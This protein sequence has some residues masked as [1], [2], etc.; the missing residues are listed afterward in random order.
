MFRIMRAEAAL[1]RSMPLETLDDGALVAHFECFG[2]TL[3]HE[4]ALR[5]LHEVVSAQSRAY[6]VLEALVTAWIP[7][8]D[9]GVMTRLMTGLGTLPNVRMTYGLM[10]LG[11]LAT[12]ER[13][14]RAYFMG[15][16]DAVAL[17]NYERALAGTAVLAGLREFLADFGHR[18]SYESD[19]MSVRFAE[20]PTALLRM[21]QL[22]V[23]AG[24]TGTAAAHAASRRE[25]RRA[26]MTEIRHTLRAACGPLGSR[27]RW[28]VFSMV[29][30]AVRRLLA[31]RDECRHVTTMLVT[32]L[33]R[34]A[35]EM[36]RRGARAGRLADSTDVF[37]LTWDEMSRLL[38]EGDTDWAAVAAQ[39]RRQRER[40]A[41]EV[42]PDLVGDDGTVGRREAST[43]ARADADELFGHG[44]SPGVVSGRVRVLRSMEDIGRLSGEIV[45]FPSIEPTLTPIFPLVRGL[46]AEMGG[47]LSHAAILAREYG[48]PAIVN[49][50]DAT[51]RLRDGDRVELDGASG[52]IRVLERATSA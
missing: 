33:R 21:I 6:M 38:R 44:V 48:L 31:L 49:V 46:V 18:G 37:F 28:S 3:L 19:V 24:A 17:R 27:L 14:A 47:L 15:E 4:R 30:R 40:D 51:R 41:E 7:N 39:R 29:C 12:Q 25:L 8:G 32:H 20:D 2:A 42:A 43:E 13:R 45:V 34:V 11:M 36:G 9:D 22:H 52:R 23:R 16:L 10:D 5:Q 1:L 35:L 50:P 26:A